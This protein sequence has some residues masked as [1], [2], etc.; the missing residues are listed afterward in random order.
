MKKAV[1]EVRLVDEA[2]E[3]T[4]QQI[5]KEISK[6]LSKVIVPWVRDVLKVAVLE[7]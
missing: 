6:E 4:N 7:T 2:S 3:V 1:I 5:E